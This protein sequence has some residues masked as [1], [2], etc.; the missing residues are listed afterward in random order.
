[1]VARLLQGQPITVGGDHVSVAFDPRESVRDVTLHDRGDGTYAI[2]FTATREAAG[3]PLRVAIQV[4]GHDVTGSP[5]ILAAS[6]TPFV[7]E[8]SKSGAIELVEGHAGT[9]IKCNGSG[10]ATC[11]QNLLRP[12]GGVTFWKVRFQTLAGETPNSCWIFLGADTL[13]HRPA[14]TYHTAGLYGW[15]AYKGNTVGVYSPPSPNVVANGAHTLREGDVAVLRLDPA[16]HTLSIRF[17]GDSATTSVMTV[18]EQEGHEAFYAYFYPYS[19]GNEV[20]L[21]PVEDADRY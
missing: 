16:A 12:D 3:Q 18:P 1:M 17:N 10:G 6:A 14:A 9:C 2:D 11:P 20:Q 7:T 19:A 15:A 21:L 13:P 4:A 8:A 5:F